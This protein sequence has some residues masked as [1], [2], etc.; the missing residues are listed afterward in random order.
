MACRDPGLYL[1]SEDH[2]DSGCGSR[3]SFPEA[4]GDAQLSQ[5]RDAR[6]L[7]FRTLKDTVKLAV[8]LEEIFLKE[9]KTTH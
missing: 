7:D 6:L 3:S 9:L 5:Q 2:W 1:Q 4:L 8:P